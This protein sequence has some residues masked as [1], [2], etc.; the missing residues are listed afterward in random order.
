MND[1]QSRRDAA[2][3]IR[4]SLT[5]A[6]TKNAPEPGPGHFFRVLNRQYRNFQTLTCRI[7]LL[8]PG[9]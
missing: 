2:Y 4:G 1:M 7:F 5:R 8:E 3:L 9:P 6:E